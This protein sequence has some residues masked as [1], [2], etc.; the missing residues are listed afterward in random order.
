MDQTHCQPKVLKMT[1]GLELDFYKPNMILNIELLGQKDKYH[2]RFTI[3]FNHLFNFD[4]HRRFYVSN[5]NIFTKEFKFYLLS[6]YKKNL[7]NLILI[8]SQKQFF[9]KRLSLFQKFCQI[10]LI[11]LCG[12]NDN[13]IIA[14]KIIY[15]FQTGIIEE[16]DE[17]NSF[18][19]EQDE[20]KYL[21]MKKKIQ[22]EKHAKD[23]EL[24][25]DTLDI[26]IEQ[27]EILKRINNKLKKTNIDDFCL[28]K[29]NDYFGINK[30]SVFKNTFHSNLEISSK[31]SMGY[32]E[33]TSFLEIYKS[34]KEKNGVIYVD[35]KK[36]PMG[37]ILKKIRK[38]RELVLKNIKEDISQKDQAKI[39]DQIQNEILYAWI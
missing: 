5:M 13:E 27:K 8:K 14:P 20:K 16:Q 36:N 28:N 7:E 6:K 12:F 9:A 38:A 4:V 34:I 1:E 11:N 39:Y 24:S 18:I 22:D 21:E 31:N 29:K 3:E 25:R 35:K 30:L 15:E 26:K 2:F 10:N 32:N 19:L 23:E 33:G 37:K 17:N